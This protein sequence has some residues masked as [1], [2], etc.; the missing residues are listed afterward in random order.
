MSND[1]GAPVVDVAATGTGG[2]PRWSRWCPTAGEFGDVC[3]GHFVDR[4]L[5]IANRG[6]CD[7]RVTGVT[8]SAPAVHPAGRDDLPD[9]RG[10][11]G[12]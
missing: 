8:S 12:D 2:R 6:P 4:E 5:V 3:L 1:P 10:R 9:R 7:L 11:V